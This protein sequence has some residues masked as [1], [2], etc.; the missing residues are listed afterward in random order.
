TRR[1][2]SIHPKT[3]RCRAA[4]RNW[5]YDAKTG[6]CNMFIFMVVVKATAT[7]TLLNKSAWITVKESNEL[8]QA[9]TL[10]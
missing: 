4:K 3:G 9:K 8:H 7:D 10:V 2:A 5:N 6:K 1:I